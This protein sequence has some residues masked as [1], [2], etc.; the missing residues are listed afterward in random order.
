MITGSENILL[1]HHISQTLAGR[2]ALFT[3]LP[4]SIGEL[5]RNGLLTD[6]VDELL[7]RGFYPSIHEKK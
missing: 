5:K 4:L 7:F 1:N 6:S 3:L 2:I